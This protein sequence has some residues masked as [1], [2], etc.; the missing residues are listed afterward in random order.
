MFVAEAVKF[1]RPIN[2]LDFIG[3]FCQGLVKDRIFLQLPQEYAYLLPEYKEYF[4]SS[5]LLVRS[6]YGLNVAA[7]VWNQDLTEWLTTNKVK[8]MQAYSFT[9]M[10]M[11]LFI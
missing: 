3:A 9:G 8:L 7:K 11:N 5:Q 1:C 4:D 2:Q 10:E 6:I